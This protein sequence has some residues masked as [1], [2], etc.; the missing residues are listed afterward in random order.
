M[1]TAARGSSEEGFQKWKDGIDRASG[2]WNA[3]DGTIRFFVMDYNQHLAG[4][5]MNAIRSSGQ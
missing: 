2:D 3:Y 4:V 5:W 1:A